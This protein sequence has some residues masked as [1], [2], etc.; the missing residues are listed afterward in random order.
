MIIFPE[1]GTLYLF[2]LKHLSRQ[3]PLRL[4]EGQ[5]LTNGKVAVAWIGHSERQLT[6]GAAGHL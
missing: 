4:L 2:N 1:S 5:L 3:N 6:S